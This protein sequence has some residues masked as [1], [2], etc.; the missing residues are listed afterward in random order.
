MIDIY[1][2]QNWNTRLEKFIKVIYRN[3][4]QVVDKLKW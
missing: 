3:H 4:R 1:I 2:A